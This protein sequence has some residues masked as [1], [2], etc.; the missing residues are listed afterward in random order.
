MTGQNRGGLLMFFFFQAEDGIRD[1]DVTGVQ[2]CALPISI[3]SQRSGASSRMKRAKS[4]KGPFSSAIRDSS[5]ANFSVSSG[6]V[7]EPLLAPRLLESL[8]LRQVAAPCNQPIIGY[9]SGVVRRSKTSR[10]GRAR[11]GSRRY[12]A[13]RSSARVRCDSG[14]GTCSAFERELN[15]VGSAGTGGCASRLRLRAREGTPA[16]YAP[17]YF[18]STCAEEYSRSAR[19]RK[20]A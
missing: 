15:P 17:G 10:A 20:R 12:S 8:P 5:S 2:T 7:I 6:T 19:G 13:S 11:V 14:T 3:K 1:A 9:R 16:L 18:V 4:A